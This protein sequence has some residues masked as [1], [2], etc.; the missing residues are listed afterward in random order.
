MHNHTL[1]DVH[2]TAFCAKCGIDSVIGDASGYPIND[3]VFVELMGLYWFNGY[4]KGHQNCKE[5]LE[6]EEKLRKFIVDDNACS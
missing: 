6:L 3:P 4:A 1:W 5:N 2:A